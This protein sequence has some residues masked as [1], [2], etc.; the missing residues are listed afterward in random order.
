MLGQK[1]LSTLSDDPD[2]LQQQLQAMA[3]P[4]AGP[5]GGPDLYRRLHGRQPSRQ[6]SI[7][8][9]RIN[10]KP[11]S[12]EYERPGFGH[13]EIFTRPGTDLLTGSSSGN[14]TKKR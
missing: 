1:E 6:S 8:E 11:F 14:T 4:G 5:N 13:I 7:R 3:G 9:V 2:E 10:T 12:P